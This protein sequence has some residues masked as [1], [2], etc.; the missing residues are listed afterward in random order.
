MNTLWPQLTQRANIGLSAAQGE[1]LS[2]YLELLL[3]ANERMNL[4]RISDRA[5]AEIQHIGDA[6]TLLPHLPSGAHTLADVGTGGGVPGIPLAIVRPDVK[7]TLIESTKKKAAFLRETIAQLELTN[8]TVD[9]RRAEL[10]GAVG[11]KSREAFDVVVVRAVATMIWLVE[12]CLPLAKPKGRMLAMK[13]PK[14]REE[15]TVVTRRTLRMLGASDHEPLVHA[16]ELANT[17]AR[18]IVQIDKN[19]H[20]DRR[21]P[22]DPTAAKGNPIT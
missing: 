10:V 4:T 7:V 3:A 6:L 18:I 12:W 16:V 2:R 15:L 11:S 21:F 1:L 20:T 14:G 5:V 9:D 22:R 13:G 8:V 17:D 19:T